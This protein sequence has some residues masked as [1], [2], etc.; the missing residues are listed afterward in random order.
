[1]IALSQG[2]SRSYGLVDVSVAAAALHRFT[3]T[4]KLDPFPESSVKT[5]VMEFDKAR[6]IITETGG[7]LRRFSGLSVIRS[8]RGPNRWEIYFAGDQWL[9]ILRG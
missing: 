8:R 3:D 9:R 4:I 6:D 2:N 7:S 5:G 1:M